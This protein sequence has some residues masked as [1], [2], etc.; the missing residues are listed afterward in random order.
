MERTI[1]IFTSLIVPLVRAKAV[2]HKHELKSW[3]SFVG[4]YTC[5]LTTESNFVWAWEMA[6]VLF[7]SLWFRAVELL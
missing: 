1:T 2:I 4:I 5:D 7:H 3:N 6:G